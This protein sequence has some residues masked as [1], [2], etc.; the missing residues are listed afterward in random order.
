[1]TDALRAARL[2]AAAYS[3]TVLELT[4]PENTPKNTLIRAIKSNVTDL[5]KKKEEYNAILKFIVGDKADGYLSEF[6][7]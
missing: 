6:C 3:V 2:E 4:D 7:K 5:D 1:M